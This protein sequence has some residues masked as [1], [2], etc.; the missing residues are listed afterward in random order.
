M[1]AWAVF[2]LWAIVTQSLQN[3]HAAIAKISYYQ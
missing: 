2:N 3:R 1:I